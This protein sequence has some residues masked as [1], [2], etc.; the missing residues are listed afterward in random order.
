MSRS[1]LRQGRLK[2]SFAED[3]D[4]EEETGMA[5]FLASRKAV[6]GKA[7]SKKGA[8]STKPAPAAKQKSSVVLKP[9]A[10]RPEAASAQS[11]QRSAPGGIC[12]G[13]GKAEAS[14]RTAGSNAI[15]RLMQ[16]IIPRS[17]SRSCS[18]RRRGCQ[19]A[20]LLPQQI[21]HHSRFRGASSLLA[22]QRMTDFW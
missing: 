14:A 3:D 9:P 5:A 4:D 21:Q 22:R 13:T 17:G 6:Q 8:G 12:T 18:I 16:A 10:A 20:S 1:K 7:G 15:F 2:P 19:P 11:T